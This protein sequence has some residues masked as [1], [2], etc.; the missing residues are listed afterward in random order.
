MDNN[1]KEIS[2]IQVTCSQMC[3]C[4][5]QVKIPDDNNAVVHCA[6]ENCRAHVYHKFC[7]DA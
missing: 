1:G 4:N 5:G 3:H 7:L 2:S 6:N